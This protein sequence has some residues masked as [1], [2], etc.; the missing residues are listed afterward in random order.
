MAAGQHRLASAAFQRLVLLSITC[1]SLPCQVPKPDTS[2]LSQFSM[3]KLPSELPSFEARNLASAGAHSPHTGHALFSAAEGVFAA[4]QAPVV[5][6][7]PSPPS[8]LPLTVAPLLFLGRQVDKERLVLPTPKIPEFK[9]PS[10]EVAPP[11]LDFKP[12][13]ALEVGLPCT[14]LP[15]VLCIKYLFAFT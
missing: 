5:V 14:S 15:L 6:C 4:V 7:V 11:K 10:L 3:P 8:S 12:P 9:A 13:P 1:V 2:K